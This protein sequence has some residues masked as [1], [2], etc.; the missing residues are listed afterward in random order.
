ML[1]SVSL[2]RVIEGYQV[3]KSV[4]EYEGGVVS[5]IEGYLVL[6]SVSKC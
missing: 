1:F 2:V 3:L 5:G 4:N 6:V